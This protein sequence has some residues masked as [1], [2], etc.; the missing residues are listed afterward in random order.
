MF[1]SLPQGSALLCIN[2]SLPPLINVRF[3]FI[4]KL[5]SIFLISDFLIKPALSLGYILFGTSSQ[6]G[7]S[8]E[9]KEHLTSRLKNQ[10]NPE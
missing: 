5:P 10:E 3:F 9:V 6:L 4:S 1:R 8:G 2:T 7:S